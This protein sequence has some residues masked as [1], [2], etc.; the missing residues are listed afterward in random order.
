[1]RFGILLDSGKVIPIS[2]DSKATARALLVSRRERRRAMIAAGA[3]APIRR[4]IG[5]IT[6][7]RGC[8]PQYF[9]CDRSVVHLVG[10]GRRLRC[11]KP[12]PSPYRPP[13]TTTTDEAKVTCRMCLRC[14]DVDAGKRLTR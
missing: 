9:A 8:G 10:K 14:I 6:Y 7:K 2:A 11:G 5:L 3:L 12:K 1:M 4:P 13:F